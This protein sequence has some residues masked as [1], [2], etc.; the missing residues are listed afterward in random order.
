MKTERLHEMSAVQLVGVIIMAQKPECIA[1]FYR[2][3]LGIPFEPAKHGTIGEHLECDYNNI[4]FAILKKAQAQPGNTVI[5]SFCVPDLRQFLEHLSLR[6][7]KPLHPIIDLGKG[8]CVSTISDPEGNAV[9][10]IQ[11][12]SAPVEVSQ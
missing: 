7:I 10:L 11:L 4:H 8:S 3:T 2:E 1:Q 5:L 6:D 12:K 9:R